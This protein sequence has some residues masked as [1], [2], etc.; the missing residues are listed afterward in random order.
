MKK[1]YFSFIVAFVAILSTT[2]VFGQGLTCD[3]WT[4]AAWPWDTWGDVQHG[5]TIHVDGSYTLTYD[6]EGTTYDAMQVIVSIMRLDS[7]SWAGVDVHNNIVADSVIGDISSGKISHDIVVPCWF[8]LTSVDPNDHWLAQVRV[9]YG[10]N[11]VVKTEIDEW[12][13]A[14][15]TIVDGG[16]TPAENP[17]AGLYIDTWDNVHGQ[18]GTYGDVVHGEKIMINGTFSQ[19][20]AKDGTDYDVTSVRLSILGFTAGWANNGH[21]QVFPIHDANNGD[22]SCSIIN[23]PL[24]VADSLPIVADLPAGDFYLFQVRADYGTAETPAVES[25]WANAWMSI[26]A[27]GVTAISDRFVEN[28]INIYPNPVV[29]GQPLHITSNEFSGDVHIKIFNV[30]GAEVYNK[31]QPANNILLNSNEFL[32]GMYTVAVKSGERM[33]VHK[34]IVSE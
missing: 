18:Y 4:K 1:I 34:L 11:G 25:L 16:M 2:S 19:K 21:N 17:P 8:P 10:K 28:G 12:A 14:W 29:K 30:A 9:R 24:I 33:A 31:I 27:G 26:I 20:F 32:P 15:I 22:L 23:S 5:D 6:F 13:N 3:T 7:A